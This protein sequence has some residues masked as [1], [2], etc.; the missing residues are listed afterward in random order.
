[1][2][3]WALEYPVGLMSEEAG[4]GEDSA[5]IMYQWLREVCSTQLVS[6]SMR[7]GG[8]GVI[9]EINESQFKHKPK[10]SANYI[11]LSIKH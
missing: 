7:L 6:S 3:W 8:P 10:V 9:V 11:L 1:M 4:I 5:C 2:W